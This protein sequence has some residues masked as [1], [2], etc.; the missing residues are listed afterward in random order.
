MEIATKYHPRVKFITYAAL[1]AVLL[2]MT[3]A[4]RIA[5]AQTVLRWKLTAGDALAIEKHQETESTVAFSGKSAATKI[6]VAAEL[7]W[8]VTAADEEKI[9]LTQTI[10]HVSIKLTTPQAAAIEFDSAATGRPTGQARGLAEALTPLVGAEIKIVMNPRGEILEATP[11]SEAARAF[12]SADPTKDAPQTPKAALAQ[13]LRRPLVVLPAEAV[14]V[15]D[16]WTVTSELP[17]AGAAMRQEAE[18]RLAGVATRDGKPL[19]QIAVTSKLSPPPDA[20]ASKEASGPLSVKSH[21]HAGTILFSAGDGRVVESEQ[22]QKLQ[23]E[24]T[25][26]ETTI[27]VTLESK[28]KTTVMPKQ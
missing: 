28:Q 16:A 27:V 25:Y 3:P 20:R 8:R 18:Y 19:Q 15:G 9:T 23:T 6:E 17:A 21:E 12:F 14:N 10:D 24:R 5:Q 22:T 1:C 26:R 2:M 4:A 13:L 11:M 7:T